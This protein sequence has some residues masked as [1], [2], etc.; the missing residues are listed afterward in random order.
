VASLSGV[1]GVFGIGIAITTVTSLTGR[2]LFIRRSGRYTTE[3][4]LL[5][6]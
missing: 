6:L 5:P 3:L 2:T 1:A 4:P